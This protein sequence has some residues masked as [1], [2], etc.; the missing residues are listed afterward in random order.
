MVE[1]V[2][3]T[4]HERQSVVPLVLVRKNFGQEFRGLAADPFARLTL[5]C[6]QIKETSIRTLLFQDGQCGGEHLFVDAVVF[7][8]I[9][10]Q[11]GAIE[12][13]I[14]HILSPLD[15]TYVPPWEPVLSPGAG[16]EAST[17]AAVL[18]CELLADDEWITHRRPMPR[19]PMPPI[20]RC[21][22]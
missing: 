10:S 2:C 5:P 17:E 4:L 12:V 11:F 9:P 13:E 20:P 14:F 1:I 3:E 22:R 7:C 18:A 21:S 8:E 19:V 15:R 16:W 6:L